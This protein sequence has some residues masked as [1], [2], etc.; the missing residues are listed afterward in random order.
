M[1]SRRL[2]LALPL[3]LVAPSLSGPARAQNPDPVAIVR[4]IYRGAD[5]Y[6]ARSALQLRAGNRE[7]ALSQSLAGLWK[8]SD[9][10][11]PEGEAPPGFD[12]ASNSNAMDVARAEVKLEKRAGPRA[13]VVARLIPGHPFVRNS[14]AENVVRYDFVRENGRWKIDDV[15]STDHDKEWSLKGILNEA[16]AQ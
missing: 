4:S 1:R 6:G 13:T 12:V 3:L 7:V 2:L 10:T 14:P 9:D 8:R 11:E 16:L 5:S 15:R